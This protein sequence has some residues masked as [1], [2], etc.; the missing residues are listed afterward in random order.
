MYSCTN[1]RKAGVALALLAVLAS[2]FLGV[3]Q[4]LAAAEVAVCCGTSCPM[5]RHVPNDSR[6]DGHNCGSHGQSG[7]NDCSMRA[8]QVP[9]SPAMGAAEYVIVAPLLP[10]FLQGAE[11]TPISNFLYLPSRLNLPTTP[12]PRSFPS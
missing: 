12:P 6:Q 7:S 9:V 11:P 3:V 5:H 2:S 10:A 4:S 8:C 1:S